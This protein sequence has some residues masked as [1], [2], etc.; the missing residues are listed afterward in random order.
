MH[1]VVLLTGSNHTQKEHL[2]ARAAELLEECIGSIEDSSEV[3]YSEAWGFSSDEE[4]ANQALLLSSEL[5]PLEVLDRALEVEQILGRD[6]EAEQAEK[7]LTRQA[8]ASRV[9]DVDVIFYDDEQIAHPR[10]EVP[11]PRVQFR[12][13]ALVPLSQIVGDYVHPTFGQSINAMLE[14]IRKKS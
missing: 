5:E 12:E 14:E 4:F 9:V 8:Y 13:F 6:R 11:H 3:C 2:L 1:R 7:R 10:L